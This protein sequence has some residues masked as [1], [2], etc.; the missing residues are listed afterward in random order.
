MGSVWGC[1]QLGRSFEV[2]WLDTLVST[3]KILS[4]ARVFIINNAFSIERDGRFLEAT[5]FG[6]VLAIIYR[7]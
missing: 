3:V 5:L 6:T 1:I 4:N 7:I 2:E